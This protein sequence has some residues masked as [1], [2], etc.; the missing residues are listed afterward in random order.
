MDFRV[1]VTKPAIVGLGEI[2]TYIARDNPEAA[3]VLGNHC[4]T[5]H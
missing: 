4:S 5:Q 2:V 1:E 3:S